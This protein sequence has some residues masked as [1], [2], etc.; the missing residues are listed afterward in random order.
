MAHISLYEFTKL[1]NK[2]QVYNGSLNLVF[3]D[4]IEILSKKNKTKQDYT[5]L[6]YHAP[7]IVRA[8]VDYKNEN[9]DDQKLIRLLSNGINAALKIYRNYDTIK[10]RDDVVK[11]REK[12]IKLGHKKLLN[13][14][15]RQYKDWVNLIASKPELSKKAA[16]KLSKII[17]SSKALMVVVG[18]GAINPGMDVFLRCC[19]LRPKTNLQFYV[20]RYSRTKYKK[21]QDTSPQL[22]SLE[23]KYLQKMGVGRKIVVYDENSNTGKTIQSVAR[24]LS[25]NVFPHR[26]ISMLYNINTGSW[27]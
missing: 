10:T 4:L 21:Y 19:D 14:E 25:K 11:L 16:V 3:A 27:K 22:T 5:T 20:V 12:I 2:A 7:R 23:I 18:H 1:T 8:L 24:Y 6:V 15:L 17:Q 26:K 9:P 13:K